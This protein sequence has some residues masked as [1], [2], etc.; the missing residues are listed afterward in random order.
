MTRL[1]SSLLRRINLSGPP[2]WKGYFLLCLSEWDK[3]PAHHPSLLETAREGGGWVGETEASL[4]FFPALCLY[5]LFLSLP[6]I[7]SPPLFAHRTLTPIA[8]SV[9]F[10][11]SRS[12][13]R[14][15]YFPAGRPLLSKGDEWLRLLY[16]FPNWNNLG[17]KQVAVYHIDF[18]PN[19]V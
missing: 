9:L 2:H 6:A 15:C 1:R 16:R 5:S 19:S 8:F 12:T 17:A 10:F 4:L 7:S 18:L 13:R 11:R 3:P 14:P